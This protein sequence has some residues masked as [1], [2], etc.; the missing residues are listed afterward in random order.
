MLQPLAMILDKLATH[1]I[2]DKILKGELPPEA[3]DE[4]DVLKKTAPQIVGDVSQ[5]VLAAYIPGIFGKSAFQFAKQPIKSALVG[6]GVRGSVAGLEFGTAQALSSGSKDPTEIAEIIGT[7]TV[8]MGLLG[9]VTSGAIP[10]TKG[11]IGEA[12]KIKGEIKA[13]AVKNGWSA[14]E[15]E[16]IANHG[17]YMGGV[18]KKE[19]VI[20]QTAQP[21]DVF[22]PDQYVAEKAAQRE[23]AFRK[24]KSFI[25][26]EKDCMMK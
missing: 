24:E 2:S 11:I 19:S 18:P 5:A 25:Q 14:S 10:V 22:N 6:G 15:A 8:A 17:G 12:V 3:L 20:E 4:I 1:Q 13:E 16:N 9:M 21:K 7:S 26:K 23:K